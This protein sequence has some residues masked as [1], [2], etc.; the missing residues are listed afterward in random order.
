MQAHRL[1]LKHIKALDVFFSVQRRIDVNQNETLF[2][3]QWY[4]LGYT[5]SRAVAQGKIIIRNSDL[6]NWQHNLDQLKGQC[7]RN[8]IWK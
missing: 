1:N 4:N 7:M 2:V 3:G 6:K 5:K 8:A